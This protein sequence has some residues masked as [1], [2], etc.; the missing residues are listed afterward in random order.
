[1]KHVSLGGLDVSR[2]DL[3]TMGMS[4]FYAGDG[5]DDGEAV[6][7]IH[8]ALEL[9]VTLTDTAENY[10]F[11]IV[12]ARYER[13]SR[14]V[15]CYKSFGWGEVF[16]DDVVRRRRGAPP[17]PSGIGCSRLCPAPNTYSGGG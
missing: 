17:A 5:A 13:A 7:I 2:L 16:G 11:Q 14:I 15:T 3:G 4:A 12:S 10:F 9:G 6:H 1:V 8:R